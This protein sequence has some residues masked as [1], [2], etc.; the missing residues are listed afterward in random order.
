MSSSRFGKYRQ[1]LESL[2]AR[3]KTPLPSLIL[4][5]GILHELTALVPL[6]G[7]FYGA[8]QLGIGERVVSSLRD[9]S[10]SYERSNTESE[11]ILES[12]GKNKLRQWMTEGEGW[13]GRLGKRYG[14]F[15]YEKGQ[16]PSRVPTDAI[17]GDIANAVVAYV[18]TK[19]CSSSFNQC[20]VF[21]LIRRHYYLC[22]SERRCTFP[23]HSQGQLS[24]PSCG[25]SYGYSEDDTTG[26]ENSNVC[27]ICMTIQY[28]YQSESHC[29]QKTNHVHAEC[30]PS[31]KE[32]FES[33]GENV[34]EVKR[35][36][37]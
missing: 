15:G 23:Q 31:Q 27:L 7:V 37:V 32:Q 13:A 8:R 21:D 9:T 30:L 19:V 28:S 29:N 20:I 10:S 16:E 35:T 14:F 18:A 4:S 24:T 25:T 2:S 22:E 34:K 11:Q 33:Q 3:T 36:K 1:A 12:W 26:I 6:A 17:A 5:F